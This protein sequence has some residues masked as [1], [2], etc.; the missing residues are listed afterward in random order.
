MALLQGNPGEALMHD[1]RVQNGTGSGEALFGRERTLG[2]Q[3]KPD[4]ALKYLRMAV[5]DVMI[6]SARYRVA[7]MCHDFHLG[8][9]AQKEMSSSRRFGLRKITLRRYTVR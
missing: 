5:Q 1:R 4:E 7:R 9:E 3:N 6:A 8:Q 2:G